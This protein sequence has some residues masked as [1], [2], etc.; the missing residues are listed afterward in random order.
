MD[1]R[2]R[3]M[4]RA[5]LRALPIGPWE[6]RFE[7]WTMA[8]I[9]AGKV[10]RGRMILT[11]REVVATAYQPDDIICAPIEGR[12]WIFGRFADGQWF[13]SLSPF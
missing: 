12:L 10:G 5:E 9:E 1:K 3:D 7:P 6:E 2:P 11:G 4:T 8:D 13:R